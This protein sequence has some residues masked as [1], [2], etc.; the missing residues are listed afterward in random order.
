MLDL[1]T[2]GQGP[3]CV[4]IAVAA[5]PFFKTECQPIEDHF[6][7]NVDIES[8][9][10]LRLKI[11]PSTLHWWVQKAPLFLSLQEKSVALP[12]VLM[13][14]ADWM[15]CWCTPDVRVWGRGPSFD[16]AIL[17][18][19]YSRCMQQLPWKYYRERCV[20]TYLCEHE[21]VINRLLP[22]AGKPHHPVDDAR[23]QI[24]SMEKLQSMVLISNDGEHD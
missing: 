23:H 1:E 7:K 13:E 14:L 11:D 24:R 17:R 19:A 8:C 3:G 16:Q 4:I 21:E 20:R 2:L 5:V 6:Y 9:L 18:E 10:D 22:F 12:K 15:K